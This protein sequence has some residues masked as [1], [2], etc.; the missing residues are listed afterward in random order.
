MAELLKEL[1][2]LK[3]KFLFDYEDEANEM[4][5]AAQIEWCRATQHIEMAI[6]ALHQCENFHKYSLSLNNK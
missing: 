2:S 1:T 5:P 4:C 6:L 3:A